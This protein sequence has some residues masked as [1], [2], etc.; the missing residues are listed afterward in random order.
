MEAHEVL[1]ALGLWGDFTPENGSIN[2]GLVWKSGQNFT[3]QVCEVSS[4]KK[5]TQIR[6]PFRRWGKFAD[7]EAE[8]VGGSGEEEDEGFDEDRDH[9]RT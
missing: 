3:F 9:V 2:G 7:L 4:P 6:W 8:E 5:G 1:T